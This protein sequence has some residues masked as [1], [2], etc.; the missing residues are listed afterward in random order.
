MVIN[1]VSKSWDDPPSTVPNGLKR[2]VIIKE[3]KLME[4]G[5]QPLR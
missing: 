1:H 4:E 3:Q 2:E 5:Y